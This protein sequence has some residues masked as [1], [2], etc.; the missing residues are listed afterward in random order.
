MK[1]ADPRTFS[2]LRKHLQPRTD[3]SHIRPNRSRMGR[4]GVA[5]R[6]LIG[7]HDLLIGATAVAAD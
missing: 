3:Q 5:V 4:A 6:T 1:K 2:D 7:A